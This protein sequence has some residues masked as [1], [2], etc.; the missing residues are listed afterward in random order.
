MQDGVP[1][2]LPTISHPYCDSARMRKAASKGVVPEPGDG[3]VPVTSGDLDRR[4][5]PRSG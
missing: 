3:L 4:S 1:F 5:H 2:E